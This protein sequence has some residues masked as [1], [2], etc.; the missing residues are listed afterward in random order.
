MD[1]GIFLLQ[2]DGSL[3]EMGAKDYDSEEILQALIA[4]YPNLLAGD[5][6]DERNP[7]RWI[8]VSREVTIPDNEDAEGRWSLDH[9]FLD[10]DGVPT[11]VEVKRSNDTRIRREV[12]GQILDYASNA[13]SYWDVD[14]IR[15]LY[16][17]A[18]ETEGLD[19]RQEWTDKVK[20]ET[21]YDEYWD[22]RT[23]PSARSLLGNF[24]QGTSWS[25]RRGHEG[26]PDWIYTVNMYSG[27]LERARWGG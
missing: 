7:R 14:K 2:K 27:W 1:S 22:A 8:L 15:S 12:V 11:L 4:K 26:S 25:H 21:S 19:P 16:E 9:L 24:R 17:V 13:S 5:Q 6:I 3:I 10:Q 18:C 23:R 20:L